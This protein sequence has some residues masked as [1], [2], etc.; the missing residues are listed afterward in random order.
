GMAAAAATCS[1]AV[2]I[3]GGVQA[4]A[5]QCINPNAP[6]TVEEARLSRIL[7]GHTL[8]APVEILQGSGMDR[9]GPAFAAGLCGLRNFAIAEN[10][11]IEQ[12]TALWLY[13]VSRAQGR[14]P[15]GTLPR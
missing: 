1:L 15:A 12:G 8:P 4:R 13:A 9:L 14:V 5:Q 7:P 10:Y 3:V 11:V 6:L 2:G